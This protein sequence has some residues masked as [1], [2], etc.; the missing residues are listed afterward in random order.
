MCFSFGNDRRISMRIDQSQFDSAAR[1]KVLHDNAAAKLA[2]VRAIG[3][4]INDLR[5][6]R[7]PL[8]TRASVL[9]TENRRV[10]KAEFERVEA[11]LAEI[12]SAIG[13]MSAE[14]E[15]ASADWTRAAQLAKRC[16]DFAI[17]HGLPLPLE[18]IASDANFFNAGVG[19]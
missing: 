11:R 2:A 17:A 15:A 13:R 5:H 16:T 3:E 4:K 12:Q 14:Q 6:A 1:L 9:Q 10:D 8:N 7:V 18:L 19:Q